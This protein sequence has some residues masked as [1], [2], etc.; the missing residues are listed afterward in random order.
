M[1]SRYTNRSKV[2]V[3]LAFAWYERQRKGLGFEFLD[4][5]ESALQNIIF[6]PEMYPIRY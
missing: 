6:F 5:V 2:D 4:C 1:K 3:E